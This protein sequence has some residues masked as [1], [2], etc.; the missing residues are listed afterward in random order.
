M[1]KKLK[2]E[3]KSSFRKLPIR[4]IRIKIL[5]KLN[6][7]STSG[8]GSGSG[9]GV[10]KIAHPPHPD[11]RPQPDGFLTLL[12]NVSAGFPFPVQLDVCRKGFDLDS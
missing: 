2:I 12:S 1:R 7:V 11:D 10:S 8:S 9:S 3:K 5:A 6:P 4:L